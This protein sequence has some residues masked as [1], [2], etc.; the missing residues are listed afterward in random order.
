MG[1]AHCQDWVSL[2]CWASFHAT[3]IATPEGSQSYCWDWVSRRA[4]ISR[5]DAKCTLGVGP[6]W[7]C[8]SGRVP[9]PG[10]C[11]LHSIY[12]ELSSCT[13]MLA[14]LFCPWLGAVLDTFMQVHTE[15]LTNCM[16]AKTSG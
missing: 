1:T 9:V 7:G 15:C 11:L 14:Q 6:L 5:S 2:Y 13:Q 4:A 8:R 10:A 3:L 16:G 12:N